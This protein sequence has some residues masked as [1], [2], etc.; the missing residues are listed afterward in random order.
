MDD[1]T[2]IKS[3]LLYLIDYYKFIKTPNDRCNL[4]YQLYFNQ[5]MSM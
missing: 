3:Y 4:T 1:I 5:P 2:E